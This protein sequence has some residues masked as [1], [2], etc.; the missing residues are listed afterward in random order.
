MTVGTSRALREVFGSRQ[1]F[2]TCSQLMQN[3][4]SG[5]VMLSSRRW[6]RVRQLGGATPSATTVARRHGGAPEVA[7]GEDPWRALIERALAE[8]DDDA[9][10]LV[11]WW[12]YPLE[13]GGHIERQVPLLPLSKVVSGL[14][15]DGRGRTT[16]WRTGWRTG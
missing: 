13:G 14:E 15:A 16:C 10:G 7:P 3:H 1:E 8:V 12:V 4:W 9:R 6:R 11:P 2:G 5:L